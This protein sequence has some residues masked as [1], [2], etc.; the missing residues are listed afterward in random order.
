MIVYVRFFYK[1]VI[2]YILYICR[3]FFKRGNFMYGYVFF[4][5]MVRRLVITL[6]L[7]ILWD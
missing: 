3:N 5:Y 1:G 6:L 2:N 7:E 4:L